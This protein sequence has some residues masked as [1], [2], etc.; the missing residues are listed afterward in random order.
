MTCGCL[1]NSVVSPDKAGKTKYL[2]VTLGK[3]FKPRKAVLDDD[4]PHHK[5]TELA[6]IQ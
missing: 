6:Q 1:A 5:A 4:L 3:P 2:G